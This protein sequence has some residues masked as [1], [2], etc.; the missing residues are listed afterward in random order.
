VAATLGITLTT[1][2][3]PAQFC[4]HQY[5]FQQKGQPM[6]TTEDLE[7]E[8]QQPIGFFLQANAF[9]TLQMKTPNAGFRVVFEDP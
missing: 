5:K 7:E 1:R 3:S 4:K 6:C 8:S 9:K 2:A